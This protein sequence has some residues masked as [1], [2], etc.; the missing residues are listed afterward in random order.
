MT[1]GSGGSGSAAKLLFF[2]KRPAER[3]GVPMLTVAEFLDRFRGLKSDLELYHAEQSPEDTGP[4][5]RRFQVRVWIRQLTDRI[6]VLEDI[7]LR[8]PDTPVAAGL[9]WAEQNELAIAARV[10]NRWIEETEPFDDV[11]RIVA[12]ILS[13]AECVTL[14]AA[15]GGRP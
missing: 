15:R 13:A 6:A 4:G 9:G 5:S 10:L 1:N 12:L 11:R 7:A 8:M 14:N 3:G 2:P